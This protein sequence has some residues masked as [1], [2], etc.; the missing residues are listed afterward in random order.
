MKTTLLIVTSSVLLMAQAAKPAAQKQART[1]AAST[2]EIPAGAKLVEP[3]I[4]RYT[5]SQG[6]TWMYRKS[7]FGVM[8][9]EE[10]ETPPAPVQAAD[11]IV[12]TDLGD[13]FRF[14]RKS[15]FGDQIWT[16]KKSELSAEEKAILEREHQTQRSDPSKQPA[17]KST[18]TSK[19]QEKP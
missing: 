14:A 7:P 15:P 18:A 1:E 4:Y 10:K 12:V 19:P 3:F 2:T 16:S 17:G 13:S 9:W 5:D 8:K 11:P 6:K